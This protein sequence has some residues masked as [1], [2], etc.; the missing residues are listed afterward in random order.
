MQRARVDEEDVLQ[1]ARERRGVESMDQIKYA[2]L[3]RTGEISINSQIGRRPRAISLKGEGLCLKVSG[4]AMIE[5]GRSQSLSILHLQ[6]PASDAPIS[7]S[8][9]E[10]LS[11]RSSAATRSST[12]C[13]MPS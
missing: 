1:A 10:R 7:L 3:E 12:D 5:D 11:A 13:H 6:F 2:V 8:L 4:Q 9:R